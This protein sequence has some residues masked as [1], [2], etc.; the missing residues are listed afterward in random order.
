MG[1]GIGSVVKVARQQ[2]KM[3]IV[4]L[5]ESSFITAELATCCG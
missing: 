4:L 5:Q 3:S 2:M 1:F